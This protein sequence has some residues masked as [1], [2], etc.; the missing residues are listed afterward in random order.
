MFNP[1]GTDND[2]LSAEINYQINDAD[3]DTHPDAYDLDS[4][5]DGLYD[6]AEANF[7]AFDT[8]Q[9]GMLNAGE[10]NLT[11]SDNGLI[12]LV[13]LSENG[14]QII[15]PFD[16]DLDQIFNFR[17]RDS[18]NDGLSDVVEGRNPDNDSDGV[19]G[20][21]NITINDLGLAVF[22]SG[23]PFTL[24]S[25][26]VDHDNDL[27]EDYR[28]H[29]SDNDGIFDV[30]EASLADNDNNGFLFSGAAFVDQFGM[31]QIDSNTPC[32]LYT[33]DAADE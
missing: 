15:L 30:A 24:R 23:S 12:S 3:L 26:I 16:T 1:L 2:A 29:D 25:Q 8:N 19:V 13:D 6:V 28:D 33:S 4:D 21:G 32:L 18:D 10:S 20:D 7:G 17:D 11:V 31:V 27:I 22:Q 14:N 5:N 9:D